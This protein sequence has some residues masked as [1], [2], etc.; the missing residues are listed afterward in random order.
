MTIEARLRDGGL[1]K[2]DVTNLQ[3]RLFLQRGLSLSA[4]TLLTGCDITNTGPVDGFLRLISRMNDGVQAALDAL[5]PEYRVAVVLCDIEGLSYEEIAA[6]L[7]VKLCTVRSRIHRGR[8]LL[9]KALA[10]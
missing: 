2:S 9:R 1:S 5:A 6:T 8:G 4:L 7:G 3:R 10:S